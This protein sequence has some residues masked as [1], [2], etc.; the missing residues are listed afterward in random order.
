MSAGCART[1]LS[2][3]VSPVGWPTLAAGSTADYSLPSQRPFRLSLPT[4]YM[5]GQRPPALLLHFHGWG[6]ALNSGTMFHE[7][8]Q[9]RHV[10]VVSPL[11]SD[12]GGKQPTSWN[13]G[14]TSGGGTGVST[15]HDPAGAFGSMC[16]RSS[17]QRKYGG[18]NQT[19]WW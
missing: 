14:G 15:C 11:G 7:A 2:P 16:Y 17:C 18:C 13:G 3:V 8:F 5:T 10:V 12:D 1:G 19:C 9:R 4:S 6:G